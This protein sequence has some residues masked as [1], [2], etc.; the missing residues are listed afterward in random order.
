[1]NIKPI[2]A[3]CAVLFACAAHAHITLEYPV[4]LAASA[5]KASFRVGHG[6]GS[7]PTRQITVSVPQG[8]RGVRPMPKPGW[9]IEIAR[10]GEAVQAVTWTAKSAQDMLASA[11]YDE[12]VLTARLPQEAGAMYWPVRQACLEG[13]Q[14]WAEVPGNGRNLS[15]LKF[16]AAFLDVIP[17]GGA[18]GHS[19]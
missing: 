9:T 15:Q 2:G 16:P 18:A 17:S 7:S 10:E 6:C 11:H 12:F 5:Y 19:H 4:A 13:S 3:A 8:V 14:D 1:M